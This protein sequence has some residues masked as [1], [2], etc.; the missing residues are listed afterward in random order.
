MA[1]DNALARELE[2]LL[3]RYAV[4]RFG[5]DAVANL[6]G[7]RWITFVV[8]HGAA[9]WSGITGASLLRA[10]YGGS[11]DTDRARWLTGARAFVKCRS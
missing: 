11:A 5:H 3:R 4:A 6:T 7:E 8:Q 9:E 2:H 10:A 1:D